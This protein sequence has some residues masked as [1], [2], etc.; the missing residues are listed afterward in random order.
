M[1]SASPRR[2][3]HVRSFKGCQSRTVGSSVLRSPGLTRRSMTMVKY[4][5]G[6]RLRQAVPRA[7]IENARPDDPDLGVPACPEKLWGTLRWRHSSFGSATEGN[8]D[9][10]ATCVGRPRTTRS[11][12]PHQSYL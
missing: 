10:A 1:R 9:P 6:C 12:D 11:P 8:L 2:Y 7:P 4:G 3:D 5:E